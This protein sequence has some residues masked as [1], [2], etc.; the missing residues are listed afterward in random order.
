MY[1]TQSEQKSTIV[2]NLKGTKFTSARYHYLK[3][4]IVLKIK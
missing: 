3:I 2:E 4:F 1:I